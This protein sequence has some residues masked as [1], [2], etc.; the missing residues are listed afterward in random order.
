M[1]FFDANKM[2]ITIDYDD[3]MCLVGGSLRGV[4]NIFVRETVSLCGASLRYRI[5][6]GCSLGR[7]ATASPDCYA[8][9]YVLFGARSTR[10]APPVRVKQGHYSYPFA[11]PIPPSAPPT[12]RFGGSGDPALMGLF[13]RDEAP[14][15]GPA[16]PAVRIEHL[17]EVV[18]YVAHSW[19]DKHQSKHAPCVVRCTAPAIL[20]AVDNGMEGHIRNGHSLVYPGRGFFSKLFN[21]GPTRSREQADCDLFVYNTTVTLADSP[22]LHFAIR[23]KTNCPY[24][25]QLVR[26]VTY[27]FATAETSAEARRRRQQQQQAQTANSNDD[28]L[29]SVSSVSGGAPRVKP[30]IVDETV[31]SSTTMPPLDA[32][33]TGVKGRLLIS[34][35]AQEHSV[36]FASRCVSVSYYVTMALQYMANRSSSMI[37]PQ[38]KIRIP[39]NIFHGTFEEASAAAGGGYEAEAHPHY[40]ANAPAEGYVVMNGAVMG[41]DA[42]PVG[43]GAQFRPAAPVTDGG[44]ATTMWSN[45]IH[46]PTLVRPSRPLNSN[47]S[48]N[49]NGINN[50]NNK[51]AAGRGRGVVGV[52]PPSLFASVPRAPAAAAV[53]TTALA[54]AAP[55]SST[56]SG[57]DSTLPPPSTSSTVCNREE[58][59][60][61]TMDR[62]EGMGKGTEQQQQGAEDER[63]RSLAN[64]EEVSTFEDPIVMSHIPLSTINN[65]RRA[66]GDNNGSAAPIASASAPIPTATEAEAPAAAVSPRIREDDPDFQSLTPPVE[67]LSAHR[68]MF[69]AHVPPSWVRSRD[70]PAEP[71][72]DIPISA[73]VDNGEGVVA[74]ATPADGAEVTTTSYI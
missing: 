52:A 11:I 31:I 42:P 5:V 22:F 67:R 64:E 32:P 62:E 15:G 50:N 45:P 4:V 72:E 9:E 16:G 2:G 56:A 70:P 13:Q 47:S 17:V 6:E 65:R 12:Q 3:N 40:A 41:Y 21:S 30:P 36:S 57:M 28:D 35:F 33:T 8:I 43:E 53:A 18:V 55:S 49:R 10:H 66:A 51:A 26:C 73:L 27:T 25:I 48:A 29:S 59:S 60:A 69:D 7:A 14:S 68:R 1:P 58:T 19:K 39:I 34:P 61:P 24:L 74:P 37:D 46:E 23:G 20:S 44:V 54:S 38:H 71:I 63:Q